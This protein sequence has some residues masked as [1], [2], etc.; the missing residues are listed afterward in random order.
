MLRDL[1]IR[2]EEFWCIHV[3]DGAMWPSHGRYLCR[4][5]HRSYPVAWANV[6]TQ[7]SAPVLAFRQLSRSESAV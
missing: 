6:P 7:R 1:W 4:V 3:H 2:I 5:C